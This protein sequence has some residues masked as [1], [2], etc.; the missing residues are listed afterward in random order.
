MRVPEIEISYAFEG[1]TDDAVARRL[2]E[3]VGAIPGNGYGGK[4]KDHL[5][6]RLTGYESAA[7]HNPWLVMIDLDVPKK[8]A[9]CPVIYRNSLL[10]KPGR[11]CPGR[12]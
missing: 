2:I 12:C 11:E 1:Q 10:P 8:V 9:D 5:L 6:K 7:I 3:H 4:G